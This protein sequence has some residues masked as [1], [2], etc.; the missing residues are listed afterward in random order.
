LQKYR[1][2]EFFNSAGGI[3]FVTGKKD[4]RKAKSESRQATSMMIWH[5]GI[6]HSF[7]I[8]I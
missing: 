5:S 7:V 2:Q 3:V 6:G 1:P 4:Q 8:R